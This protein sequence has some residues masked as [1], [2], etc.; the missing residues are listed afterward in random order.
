MNWQPISTFNK[1]QL[2][3][4]LV[5]ED[6]SQRIFMWNPHRC[7]GVWEHPHGRGNVVQP[8]DECANPT[9]WSELPESPEEELP[10]DLLDFKK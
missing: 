3:L 5:Y 1:K 6:S 4:V 2:Q 7:G 9:H 8:G 10:T